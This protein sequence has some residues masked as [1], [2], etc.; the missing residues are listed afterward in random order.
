MVVQ[1]HAEGGR[2]LGSRREWI[3]VQSVS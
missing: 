1:I 2:A 3:A